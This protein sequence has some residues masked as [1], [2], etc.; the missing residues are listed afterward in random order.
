MVIPQRLVDQIVEHAR[1]GFPD[2]ACGLIASSDGR[3][4]RVY[5]IDNIDA[6]PVSY[7]MD[8][9]QQL[10]AMMEIDDNEWELGAIFHSHTRTRAYPSQ[11]D[12][13]LAFYADTLYMIISLADER[14]PDLRAYRIVDAQIQEVPVQIEN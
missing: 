14:R 7:R 5:P 13:Q 1:I 4:I 10:Q 9:K 3:A 11:T 6:S 12:V 2:E 8:P